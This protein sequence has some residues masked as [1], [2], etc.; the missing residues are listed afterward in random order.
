MIL[1]LAFSSLSFGSNDYKMSANKARMI[2]IHA[3]GSN[4]L[5]FWKEIQASPQNLKGEITVA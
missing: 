4:L 5:L 2:E 1:A 3:G